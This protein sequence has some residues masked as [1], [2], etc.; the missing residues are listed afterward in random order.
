MS[1]KIIFGIVVG[2]LITTMSAFCLT[3]T[4]EK[5][6]ETKLALDKLDKK[7]EKILFIDSPA[8]VRFFRAKK[9]WSFH[10]TSLLNPFL[11]TL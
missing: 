9:R 10:S 2:I 5:K 1:Q 8:I 3:G 7:I 4:E 11:R 6:D